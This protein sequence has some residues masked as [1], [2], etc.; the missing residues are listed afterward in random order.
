MPWTRR[1]EGGERGLGLGL[2]RVGAG[3]RAR[4]GVGARPPP[5]SA[6]RRRPDAQTST[7]ASAAAAAAPQ[8]ARSAAHVT[9]RAS[10]RSSCTA[11]WPSAARRTRPGSSRGSSSRAPAPASSLGSRSRHPRAWHC[12]AVCWP[13]WPR[14]SGRIIDASTALEFLGVRGLHPAGLREHS[15]RKCPPRKFRQR[16]RDDP[17]EPCTSARP[18]ATSCSSRCAASRHAACRT[19]R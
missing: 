12:M 6:S 7:C 19:P 11:S 10:R 15:R 18:A 8:A 14:F 4:A 17:A 3:A 13:S 5:R 9:G 1:A 2:G 16:Q